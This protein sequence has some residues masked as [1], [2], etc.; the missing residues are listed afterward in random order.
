VRK[1]AKREEF[2]AETEGDVTVVLDTTMDVEL[3]EE[4]LLREL[5]RSIQVAR[6]NA[7]LDISS[8]IVL[9]L[10]EKNDAV[11]G[12]IHKY[13]DKIC[14]EVLATELKV[15]V[16]GGHKTKVEIDGAKVVITFKVME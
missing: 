14:E 16:A 7:G 11:Y 8:R 6:Q 13:G 3:V 4:G 2:A 15:S 1:L 12:I 9:G 5:I 10:A